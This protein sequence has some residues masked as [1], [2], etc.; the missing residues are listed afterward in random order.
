VAAQRSFCGTTSGPFAKVEGLFTVL[1]CA[2]CQ[3][4]R[5]HGSGPFPVMTALRLRAGLNQLPTWALEKPPTA[6]S[7]QSCVS[8]WPP[9]SRCLTSS[10]L[11]GVRFAERE[12]QVEQSTSSASLAKAPYII[13][14]RL[15]N[16]GRSGTNQGWQD[17]SPA[18]CR[19]NQ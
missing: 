14:C 8:V 15:N 3:A 18:H 9:V 19:A 7:L 2:D 6:T 17:S 1:M 13:R 5:G 11:L 12:G 16:L 10:P 4:V